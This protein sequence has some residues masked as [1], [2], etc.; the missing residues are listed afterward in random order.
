MNYQTFKFMNILAENGGKTANSSSE[1]Q[2][3][4]APRL[5]CD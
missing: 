1:A 3:K 5:M 4:V 2:L